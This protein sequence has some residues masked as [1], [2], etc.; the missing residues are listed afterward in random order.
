[1]HLI[2]AVYLSWIVNLWWH[3]LRFIGV[4]NASGVG[5][6]GAEVL[7][8]ASNLIKDIRI[9]MLS[10]DDFTK[11]INILKATNTFWNKRATNWFGG[12][13][14]GGWLLVGLLA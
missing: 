9:P 13:G 7:L 2:D 3:C 6:T 11:V 14:R 8:Q 1:M 10:D 12:L 5:D 4:R